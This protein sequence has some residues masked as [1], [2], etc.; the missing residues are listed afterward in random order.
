VSCASRTF[1]V[2]IAPS[3]FGVNPSIVVYNGWWFE[4]AVPSA[5]D[6]GDSDMSISCP[7]VGF[8]MAVGNSMNQAVKI[9]VN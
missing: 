3:S 2:G 7:S 8:C 1:C 4:K 5:V 9:T 6:G